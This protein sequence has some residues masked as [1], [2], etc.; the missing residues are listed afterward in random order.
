MGGI[1]H[2][3]TGIQVYP[4]ECLS[5]RPGEDATI[6]IRV[7]QSRVW[8]SILPPC[9]WEAI[10]TVEMV[11]EVIRILAEARI[12]ILGSYGHSDRPDIFPDPGPA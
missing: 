12:G 8:L 3:D 4:G 7:I 10:M 5:K 9:T 2:V 6:I 1:P 11:E